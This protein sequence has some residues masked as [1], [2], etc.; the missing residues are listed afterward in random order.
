MDSAGIQGFFAGKSVFITGVTGLVGKLVLEKLLRSCSD[1]QKVYVLVRNKKNKDGAQR[2]KEIF[3][4]LVSNKPI[5][6]QQKF[7]VR[8]FKN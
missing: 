1:L 7:V 4:T 3:D 2:L 8:R 6:I 5:S